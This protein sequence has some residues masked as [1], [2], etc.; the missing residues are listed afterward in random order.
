M[1]TILLSA[2]LATS[3]SA[4][5]TPQQQWAAQNQAYVQQGHAAFLADQQAQKDR[6]AAATVVQNDAIAKANAD[7]QAKIE[8]E[9]T[10]GFKADAAEKQIHWCKRTIVSAK[11]S[12]AEERRI[13]AVSGV[14][15]LSE[16]RKAGQWIITCE[17]S[18]RDAW[19]DYKANG[20]TARTVAD[21]K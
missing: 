19:V 5:M 15:D 14:V 13:E 16:K 21:I 7:R 4:C 10:P 11:E 8:F 6:I 3:L 1:K 12:L 2:I 9:K 18:I 17:N 20:G